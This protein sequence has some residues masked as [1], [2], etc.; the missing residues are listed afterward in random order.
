MDISDLIVIEKHTRS[1]DV[2]YYKANVSKDPPT[3]KTR[4][5]CGCYTTEEELEMIAVRGLIQQH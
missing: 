3:R 2:R 1:K 5:K 4:K